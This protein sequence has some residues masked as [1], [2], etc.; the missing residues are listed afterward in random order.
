MTNIMSEGSSCSIWVFLFVSLW[1]DN[2][3]WKVKVPVFI[4]MN[5]V[6]SSRKKRVDLLCIG[7]DI[8]QAVKFDT[9]TSLV[10]TLIW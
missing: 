4:M 6:F 10:L 7:L 1:G 3:L 5:K 2:I 9:E 8:E